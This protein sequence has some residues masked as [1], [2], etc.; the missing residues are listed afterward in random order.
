MGPN[1]YVLNGWLSIILSLREYAHILKD[2]QAE[3][4]WRANAKTVS[5][6]LPL[7]DV[8]AYCNSRYTLNGHRRLRLTVSTP[9]V[10]IQKV[11]IHVPS[12]GTYP[13]VIKEKSNKWENHLVAESVEAKAG[14]ICLKNQEAVLNVLFSRFSF[15][16]ENIL[17]LDLHAPAETTL[18][19]DISGG[20]FDPKRASLLQRNWIRI[21]QRSLRRGANNIRLKIPWTHL[22]LVGHPTTFKKIGGRYYN[23]YHFIHIERLKTLYAWTG[24]QR[25]LDYV[26]KWEA[27][28]K[29]WPDIAVYQGLETQPYR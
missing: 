29:S 24:Q 9:Q 18:Q 26:R 15:P 6:L 17:L 22:E 25:F 8:P 16:R 14:N 11:S 27:Y 1:G 10:H 4:L 3:A 21:D 12:E 13:F 23:V 5:E 28:V 7:Y 19:V 2:G 20:V